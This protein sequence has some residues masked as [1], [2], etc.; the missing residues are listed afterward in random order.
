MSSVWLTEGG[1]GT[2]VN[3]ARGGWGRGVSASRKGK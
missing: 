2:E 1:N 3:T